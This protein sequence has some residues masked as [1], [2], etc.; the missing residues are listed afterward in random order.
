MTEQTG[1]AARREVADKAA[2]RPIQYMGSKARMLD[3]IEVAVDAVDPAG[4]PALDLFSGSGVVASRL[5]RSRPVTAVD[6]QEY[7]RV[8]SA[9]LLSPARFGLE[10]IGRLTA[11]ARERASELSEVAAMPLLRLEREALE[12]AAV[13]SLDGLCEV[14]EHGSPVAFERGDPPPDGPLADALGASVARMGAVVDRVTLFRFY[15]GVYFGYRQA[16]ALDCLLEVVRSL[17]SGP[18]RDTGMAAALGA[19]SDCVTSVGSHFAQPVR[20]RDREG[21][22]K[23]SV[24]RKAMRRRERDAFARFAERLSLYAAAPAAPFEASAVRD[25]Y[26]RFLYGHS[27]SVGVVYADPPYTRDHYS[28]FYHVLETM[29]RGD[30]P[31]IARV[32]VGGRSALSRGLYRRDRHQ[33][34]FCIRS[35][36]PGAFRELF[37]GAMQLGAPLVLSYSPYSIGTVARPRPRLLRVVELAEIASETYSDVS[38]QSSGSFSHSKFNAQHFNG[39]VDREA[40]VFL[41]CK[42]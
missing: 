7:A 28:R 34:P 41:V 15:G 40:E 1:V 27:G 10:E 20:P 2:F 8:L 42:P 31:D 25:D 4:G 29:A 11:R 6:V 18:V 16:L 23:A 12:A 5:G 32:R 14:I 26:R 3:S 17:P 36:A 19:A 9:A 33:S 37:R 39:K 30:D 21:E 22:P 24:L 38:V 35:Q 13:G